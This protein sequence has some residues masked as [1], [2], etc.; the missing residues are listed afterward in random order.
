MEDDLKIA[1]EL[2]ARIGA[3]AV[4]SRR[5][6]SEIVAEALEEGH[7]LAWQ[8]Y[9]LDK[10]TAGLDAADRGDFATPEEVEQVVN[11][12]RPA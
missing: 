4:R 8:E 12:Y 6:A 10:V 9:Y 7:S 2:R 1:P 11:K 5:S 3:V